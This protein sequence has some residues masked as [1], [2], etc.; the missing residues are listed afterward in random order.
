MHPTNIEAWK[1]AHISYASLANNHTLG[2][3]EEGLVETVGTVRGAD[4]KYA[5]AGG[6]KDEARRPATITLRSTTAGK[7]DQELRI[8]P[9]SD[10]PSDRG[11][12]PLFHLIDYSTA[13]RQHLRQLSV[14][15]AP[16]AP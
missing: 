11:S 16:K 6:T 2:N 12:V 1:A 9:A 15:S 10:H 14:A 13:T 5:G 8:W 7:A 3:S 4:I